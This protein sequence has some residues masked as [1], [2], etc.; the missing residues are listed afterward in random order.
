MRAGLNDGITDLQL[1]ITPLYPRRLGNRFSDMSGSDLCDWDATND[2]DSNPSI[3]VQGC[4]QETDG[5]S[6]SKL[7]GKSGGRPRSNTAVKPFVPSSRRREKLC[8]SFTFRN[9]CCCDHHTTKPKVS[10]A[11][12]RFGPAGA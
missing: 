10:T 6:P 4:C 3:H 1:N 5:R 8:A 11:V 2:I 12:P 9:T 7:Y